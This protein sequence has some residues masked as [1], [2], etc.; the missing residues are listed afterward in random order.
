[1]FLGAGYFMHFSTASGKVG[2]TAL[3]ET[4]L[5]YPK[6]SH[7]CLQF[8]YYHS[9]HTSDGL[10]VWVREYDKINPNGTLRFIQQIP[11]E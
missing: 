7:Q 4:R 5:L 10:K 8:F 1:M 11:G 2:D 3:L 6:H 9:G